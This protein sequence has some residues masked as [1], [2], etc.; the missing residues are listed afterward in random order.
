MKKTFSLILL[1]ILSLTVVACNNKDLGM[2]DSKSTGTADYL[3]NLKTSSVENKLDVEKLLDIL[4]IELYGHYTSSVTSDEWAGLLIDYTQVE[5]WGPIS[6][7]TM[8]EKSAILLALIYNAHDIHWK[9]PDDSVIHT[10]S[11]DALSD[12]YGDIKDYG[13]SIEN[14]KLLLV[15][16][17][18]YESEK[19]DPVTMNIK[20]L[21]TS[22][23]T[24]V[25][26]NHTNNEYTYGEGFGLERKENG[27]WVAVETINGCY[28]NA[29]AYGLEAKHEIERKE[30]WEYCYGKLPKGQ[31]RITK[32]F[33]DSTYNAESMSGKSYFI[34]AE[35]T[36]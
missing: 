9:L 2:D 18:Y 36:I 35:F 15:K 19:V 16:L 26:K 34:S 25:I 20:D 31:Y 1:I 28:V 23:L 11:I 22:G 4:D 21:T 33:D 24:M 6:E 14:L 12:K 17:G 29:I 7:A 3:F 32:D 8:L 5:G 30:N 10:M 13:K 27:K